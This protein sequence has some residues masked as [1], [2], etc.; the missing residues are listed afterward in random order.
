MG[1]LEAGIKTY[2]SYFSYFHYNYMPKLHFSLRLNLQLTA[3]KHLIMLFNWATK[4][5]E[6]N[7]RANQK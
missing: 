7:V 2:K 5:V 6:C 1:G 4:A 3:Q